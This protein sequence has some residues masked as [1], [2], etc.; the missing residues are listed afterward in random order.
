MQAV[1]LDLLRA[2]AR[3][4]VM[5]EEWRGN[6]SGIFTGSLAYMRFVASTLAVG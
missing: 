6:V 4:T 2:S 3:A 5:L 1:V